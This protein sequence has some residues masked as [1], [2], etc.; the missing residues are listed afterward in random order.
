M[1][2]LDA[3]L[4]RAVE[5]Q[6]GTAL[7]G[8][9][10]V[11]GGDINQAR[12]LETSGGR[13]FL[14]FNTGARSADMFEKEAKGLEALRSAGAVRVPE[15]LACAT[16][17]PYAFLLLEYIPEGHR[18]LDFWESFGRQLAALHRHS[19]EAFGFGHDNYIGSLPQP[20]ACAPTWAEFY[21]RQRLLPQMALARRSERLD[22]DDERAL[23]RLIER[24]P[25]LCPS[26]PPALIHGDLWSGNFLADQAGR[27]V[28]IDPA[29]CYA[30]RE[31]DLAMSR[32]FGGFHS[33][34]YDSYREAYPLSPGFEQRLDIYQLYYLLVHVNLFGGG[35]V[36]SVRAILRHFAG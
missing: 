18:S 19:A 1:H 32:L 9:G 24:V 3:T 8:V 28:L 21:A 31:M 7:Q 26:E 29:V 36:S 35:Y 25:E 4:R 2:Q 11:G 6:L 27:P 20:N 12:L 33:R 14:K 16:A 13:F 30:H 17:P 10:F 15:V 34:F 23:H 5:Q 22:A